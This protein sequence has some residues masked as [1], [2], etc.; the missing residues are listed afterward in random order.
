[1]LASLPPSPVQS[2]PCA[3]GSPSPPSGRSSKVT[4]GS[5][6]P[7][8]GQ[9]ATGAAGSEAVESESRSVSD[10]V[11]SSDSD[12]AADS[13]TSSED[14]MYTAHSKFHMG[15]GVASSSHE[16]DDKALA[17]QVGEVMTTVTL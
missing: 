7:F 3:V 6:A 11:F 5:G 1:M 16:L 9:P 13:D 17:A 10:I 12:S 15:H 4:A 14:E 8:P 2:S